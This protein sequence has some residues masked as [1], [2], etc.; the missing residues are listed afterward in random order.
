[1]W[2]GGLLDFAPLKYGK[3]DGFT[4]IVDVEHIAKED[5][6]GVTTNVRRGEWADNGYAFGQQS[7]VNEISL[8][9]LHQVENDGWEK[10]PTYVITSLAG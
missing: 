4:Q 7:E 9:T 10:E 8:D 2:A 3:T 6:P 5:L 1:M